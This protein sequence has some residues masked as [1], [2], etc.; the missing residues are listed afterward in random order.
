MSDQQY[1]VKCSEENCTAVYRTKEP[2]NSKCK[3]VCRLHTPKQKQKVFFQK[4][5]FDM[6]LNGK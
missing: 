4:F 1:E 2:L 5:Q 3:F 6:A